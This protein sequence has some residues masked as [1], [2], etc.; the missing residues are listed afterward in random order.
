MCVA[1]SL[2]ALHAHPALLSPPPP[3][4]ADVPGNHS[5]ARAY[6]AAVPDSWAVVND[7]DMVAK[8]AKFVVLFKRCG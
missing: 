3:D 4:L 8:S 5:F 2:A 7:Q 1:T 6:G